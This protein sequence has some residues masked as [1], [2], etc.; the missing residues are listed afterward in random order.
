M[1]PFGIGFSEFLV[2]VIVLFVVV[3]PEK[4]PDILRAGGK[5]IRFLRESSAELKRALYV[6]ELNR[7]LYEPMKSWDPLKESRS[8]ESSGPIDSTDDHTVDVYPH[9]LHHDEDV[10]VVDSSIEEHEADEIIVG[11]PDPMTVT[12]PTHQGE[13]KDSVE[14]HSV[15]AQS[16][17]VAFNEEDDH[18][19]G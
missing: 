2:I 1:L 10:H 16:D 3:G 9:S 15:K 4:I 7:D 6:E 17:S 11:R 13:N 5:L 14:T 12:S 19:H 8:Q 18:A